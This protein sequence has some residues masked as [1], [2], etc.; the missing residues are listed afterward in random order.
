V[1]YLMFSV[2]WVINNL[3]EKETYDPLWFQTLYRK[4]RKKY[5][6]M[7]SAIP[8]IVK[9]LCVLPGFLIINIIAFFKEDF[10]KLCVRFWEIL[11]GK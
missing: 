3:V 7:G 9:I 5:T 6:I 11:F 2:F 1:T 8:V 10:P 4:L